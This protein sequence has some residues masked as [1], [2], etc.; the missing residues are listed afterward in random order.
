[1]PG[2][3]PVIL[4]CALTAPP[5][6]PVVTVLTHGYS[7]NGEKGVWV[8]AM[9]GAIVARA[10][11]GAVFRHDQATGAWEEVS[12]TYEPAAAPLVLIFRWLDDFDKAG[13]DWGFAEA[14]GDA[15][16]AALRD[17]VL[18]TVGG[19]PLPPPVGGLVGRPLHLLGHS[20]GAIVN[21]EAVRRLGAA[22]ISVDHVTTMDPHPVNGTLDAPYFDFDWGDPLPQ[23]WSNVVWADNYWRA[24]GGGLIDAFDFDGIPIPGALDTELDE[25]SL[26]CCAYGFSHSDVHL[27]YHGTIDIG[28]APCDGEECI[29]AGMRLTWWPEGYAQ[30]GFFYARLGGGSSQR[31]PQPAGTQPGAVPSLAGGSF[32]EASRAGWLYHG[33]SLQGAIVNE[34]GVTFLKLGAGFGPTA[35]HNRFHLPADAR[36]VRFDHR[37]ITPDTGAGDDRLFLRLTSLAGTT[38]TLEPPLALGPPATGWVPGH[39][40]DIPY[41]V[42]RGRTYTLTLAI[43]S[44]ATAVAVV[45]V[46]NLEIATGPLGDVDGDGA[47]G[48]A[49]LLL[50]LAAW[51][52]CPSPPASCPADL[53][54]DGAAGITD[55]LLILGSWG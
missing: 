31:P 24:D 43:E 28:P 12:G 46:E 40:I 30:R 23:K 51:G 25:E 2:M 5:P 15:L 11:A 27:W 49:D 45:G 4:L 10:G 14:A 20:R 37:L 39:R 29:D 33:G 36:A 3:W 35:V 32:A 22:G 8:E 17:P 53:D 48:I 41:P 18:V 38:V 1:M 55:L 44:G 21:S 9:A 19:A 13:P 16:A 52:P 50:L 47:T 26:E 7:L 34:G 42:P 54:D 6:E